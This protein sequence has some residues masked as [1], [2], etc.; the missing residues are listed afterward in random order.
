V[1]YEKAPKSTGAFSVL[2]SPESS[3]QFH[4]LNR[5]AEPAA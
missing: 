4:T 5:V 2:G 3:P 1:T